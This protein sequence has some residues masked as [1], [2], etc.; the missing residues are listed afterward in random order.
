MARLQRESLKTVSS[1]INK[2]VD[3][4][5]IVIDFSTYVRLIDIVVKRPATIR[6]ESPGAEID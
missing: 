5:Q 2:S 1:K 3:K 4:R 6:L